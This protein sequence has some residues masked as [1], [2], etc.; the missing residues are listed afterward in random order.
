[1]RQI[2]KEIKGDNSGYDALGIEFQKG[3]QEAAE[4]ILPDLLF[5]DADRREI[6]NDHD[7]ILILT[8]AEIKQLEK[9]ME[10]ET[11]E[12]QK[13]MMQDSQDL[14]KKMDEQMNQSMDELD[15]ETREMQKGIE[16]DLKEM[17]RGMPKP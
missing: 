15:Q 10:K 1:L 11:R 12:L 5:T 6:L 2:A 8:Q 7:G 17:E 3:T 4:K 13:D 14:N 9:Q 16:Q